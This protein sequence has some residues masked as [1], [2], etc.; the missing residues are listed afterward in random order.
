MIKN[1]LV[2]ITCLS[3]NILVNGQEK[4]RTIELPGNPAPVA[5]MALSADQ[6]RLALATVLGRVF[7]LDVTTDGSEQI[8]W[9]RT[10]L[11]GF[12]YGARVKFSSDG[13]HILLLELKNFGATFNPVKIRSRGFVILDAA[14][15]QT[16]FEKSGV[17]SAD[18][19]PG[20]SAV[21]Y[22]SGDAI[23]I[24]D[25]DTGKEIRKFD[26]DDAEAVAISH[27]G[28]LLAASYDPSRREF[29]QLE[30]VDQNRGELRNAAKSKRLIA[31]FDLEAGNRLYQSS[32]ETDIVFSMKFT[33]DDKYLVYMTRGKGA[34][35]SQKQLAVFDFFRMEAST[36]IKDRDF[37]HKSNDFYGDY[38][39]TDDNQRFGYSDN[40]GFFKW[41]KRFQ[42]FPFD[43]SHERIARFAYQ[44]R[45][46]SKN[47]FTP[48]FALR[49]DRSV[50]YLSNGPGIIIWDYSLVPD[51]IA[52]IEKADPDET[53]DVASST[54][55]TELAAGKLREYIQKQNI[56]GI[57]I[58]DITLH[59]KGE[60]ATV[61]AASDERTDIR[62]QNLLK[63]YIRQMRFDVKIA[64]DQRI[65]FRY[66]FDIDPD[67][68]DHEEE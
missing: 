60:V 57:F 58:F 16:V 24:A 56:S 30:S 19:L 23:R 45:F 29:K 46:G 13:R 65:K 5:G 67:Q 27:N 37:N 43:G 52:Y 54:L 55:D 18:L 2:I 47:I 66:T 63:D 28:K 50:A 48:T 4:Y 7:V 22:T 41:K 59:K 68:A 25:L 64:K 10:D 49:S 1:T 17:F 36:G 31:F 20:T 39:I 11:A 40:E 62:S 9:K 44:G 42:I 26:L 51:Y 33:S 53:I 38:S 15:G 34:E 35:G 61:F 14:T 21:A 8:L 32:D 6:T 3:L 12:R